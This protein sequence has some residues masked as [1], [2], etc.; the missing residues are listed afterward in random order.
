[1]QDGGPDV[2]ARGARMS[3][4]CA[5]VMSSARRRERSWISGEKKVKVLTF[6]ID[7]AADLALGGVEAA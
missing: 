5:G 6:G 4:N 3:P 2:V 1:M 7:G